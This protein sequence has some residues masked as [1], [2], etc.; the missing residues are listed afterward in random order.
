[1][2]ALTAVQIFIDWYWDEK[3]CAPD[4]GSW[5]AMEGVQ[6]TGPKVKQVPEVSGSTLRMMGG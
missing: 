3:E 1:M 4:K 2:V 6:S 5:D